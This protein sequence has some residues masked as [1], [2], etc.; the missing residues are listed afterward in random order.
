MI[1]SSDITAMSNAPGSAVPLVSQL[2]TA[3]LATLGVRFSSAGGFV[4][5]VNHVPG[6]SPCTPTPFNIIGGTSASGTLSYTAPITASFFST[7]N[8]AIKATT[9]F[10]KVL[11]DQVPLGQGSAFLE[12]YDVNGIL[13]G[14]TSAADVGAVGTGPVL[15]LSLTGIHS[16][17]FFSD[18]ATI[19]FDNFEFGTLTGVPEPSS[20]AMMLLGFGLAGTALRR[21]RAQRA[22]A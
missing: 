18:N 11:G 6:C 17:R 15:S 16:V 20:W 22:V 9:N 5:V 1:G 10:V 3:Y 14:S 12:A 13:L 2:S 21:Q 7:A 4:A 19:G 8:T